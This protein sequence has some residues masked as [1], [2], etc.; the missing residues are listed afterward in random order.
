MPVV[1]IGAVLLLGPSEDPDGRDHI[2]HRFNAFEVKFGWVHFESMLAVKPALWQMFG[3]GL[4]VGRAKGPTTL[5][6][7]GE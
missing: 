6:K 3:T 2:V 4:A 1:V 7:Y 5:S